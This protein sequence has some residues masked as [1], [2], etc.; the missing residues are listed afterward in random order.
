VNRTL[1]AWPLSLAFAT[2]LAVAPTSAVLAATYPASAVL[3]S[4]YPGEKPHI[5][6]AHLDQHLAKLKKPTMH[7]STPTAPADEYFGR[8]KFSILGVRNMV[9]DLNVRYDGTVQRSAMVL[10][11]GGGIEEAMRVWATRYPGDLWLAHN[12]F[13]LD[14]I[15]MR[16]PTDEGHGRV[17]EMSQWI[18]HQYPTTFYGKYLAKIR[19]LAALK[20]QAKPSP[21]AAAEAATPPVPLATSSAAVIIDAKPSPVA[22]AIATPPPVSTATATPLDLPTVA[23]MPT[24]TGY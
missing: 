17:S 16:V 15:Y 22:T 10:S 21:V 20:A 23:P 1:L 14:E 7:K 9:H 2:T 12:A 5:P 13:Q 18:I 4:T 24:P 3:A 11:V 8:Q 19:H 6:L